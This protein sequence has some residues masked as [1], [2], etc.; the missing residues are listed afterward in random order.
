MWHTQLRIA[1]NDQ[2]APGFLR[3]SLFHE[4]LHACW[5]HSGLYDPEGKE[6]EERVVRHMTPR[7]LDVLRSNPRLVAW[8]T[9][10]P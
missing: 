5:Q 3:D 1:V 8:L 7:I 2:Q 6:H 10:K 4:V 9:E